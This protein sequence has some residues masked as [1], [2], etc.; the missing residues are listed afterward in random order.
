M[1]EVAV[2]LQRAT[3]PK[4][5]SD[6]ETDDAIHPPSGYEKASKSRNEG[7][8]EEQCGLPS[9]F[10]NDLKAGKGGHQ[11]FYGDLEMGLQ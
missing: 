5:G 6:V 8:C 3:H 2:I 9:R 1:P 11:G 4:L 10:R 7:L